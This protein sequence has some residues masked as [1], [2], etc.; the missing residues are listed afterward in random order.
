MSKRTNLSIKKL[1]R[2][3]IFVMIAASL[4][5]F[6]ALPVNEVSARSKNRVNLYG[7]EFTMQNYFN[8]AGNLTPFFDALE[9][10]IGPKVE[11]DPAKIDYIYGF[12]FTKNAI[13]MTWNTGENWDAFEPYVGKI[14][15]FTQEEAAALPIADEYHITF[16][17]SIGDYVPI[18]DPDQKLAPNVSI[19]NDYTL[20]ISIP[21]GTTIGDGYNA[22]IYLVNSDG[23]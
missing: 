7:V 1:K 12:D 11:I 14:G 22:V 17:K 4:L 21:G 20:V 6:L 9:G 18:A 5:G 15:G 23:P 13:R 2:V 19:V 8:F 3:A 10:R 16:S